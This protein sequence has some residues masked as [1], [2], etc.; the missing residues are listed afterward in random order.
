V[1]KLLNVKAGKDNRTYGDLRD[2][3]L[4]DFGDVS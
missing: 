3:I 1:Q 2:K 4:I